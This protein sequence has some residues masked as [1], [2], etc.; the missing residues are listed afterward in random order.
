MMLLLFLCW[1]SKITNITYGDIRF[2]FYHGQFLYILSSD[3]NA[4]LILKFLRNMMPHLMKT[5]LWDIIFL[6][7]FVFWMRFEVSYSELDINFM[8]CLDLC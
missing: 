3:I 8:L 7:D 2:D 6:D 1:F 5:I 4:F